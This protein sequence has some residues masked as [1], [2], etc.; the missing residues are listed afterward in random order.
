MKNLF[1]HMLRRPRLVFLSVLVLMVVSAVVVKYRIRMVTNLD[2]YMP[3]E[4]PAF[5]FSDEA[6]NRFNIRDAILIVLEHPVTV[7]NPGTLEKMIRLEDE[8][9]NFPEIDSEF[10]TSLHT[11]DNIVATEEG[12]DVRSFFT[13]PPQRD[14]ECK[15]IRNLVRENNMIYGR[16]VSKDEIAALIIVDL[17]KNTFTQDLYE[18][19]MSLTR[20]YQ[21]PEKIYLAGRPIVEGTMAL[22]GPRDMA[23]M[24][25]LVVIVIAL[26][27]LLVLRSWVR[28]L[29]SL[30]VVLA[31][32]LGSFA[33]MTG[34]GI[35]FYTVTIMVPVML[36]A[37]GVA[38]GIHLYNQADYYSRIHPEA[39]NHELAENMID[40]ILSPV[41]F[42]ALTTMAGFISLLTS[43]VYP[44][45]Y[46]GIFSAIGVAGEFVLSLLLIPAGMILFGSRSKNTLSSL[47]LSDLPSPQK[48]MESS[49]G[50][51]FADAILA[52]PVRVFLVT[53]ILLAVSVYGI[54]RVWINT[55]FLDNFERDSE[56]VRTD[57]LVNAR[58]GG[59]STFNV[60]LDS[61]KEDLFKDPTVLNLMWEA[62]KG[63]LSLDRVGD[64]MSI[65]DY[66]RR[67]NLVMHED[68][69]EFET[70]P[71]SSD[72]IAQY[73]LLYELSGNP[74]NLWKLVDSSYKSANMK[75]QL[76]SDDSQTM[77]R[78]MEYFDSF[79]EKFL[80]LGVQVGYAGSGYK[81]MVF[82]DLILKGQISSLAL[83]VL[84]VIGLVAFM[85]KDILLGMIAAIPVGIAIVI[86][87]GIMGLF[88]VPLTSST[89]LISSIAVGIGVDY[90]IH[91]IERYRETMRD[92]GNPLYAGR[93]A[94]SLTGRAVF[95]NAAI[96]IS[97]FLVLLF[98]VFPPNRQVGAL[99]SLNMVTAFFATI[100][101]LFLVLRKLYRISEEKEK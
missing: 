31:S 41:L 22:L 9:T 47:P 12:L 79:R 76:K 82:A 45:K 61:G 26:V 46:F 78:I 49:L 15:E 42:A 99:V 35:P 52:H 88:D 13:D 29:I 58:F 17:P 50:G 5:V 57:G 34:L 38:Y 74:E 54:G 100:T 91:F 67:M 43:Q 25:P 92:T 73:L 95:L 87:F 96:V 28:M 59:T 39:N 75:I 36:I 69:V 60:I 89:A 48:T 98:S 56:I 33:L 66:L 101:V 65:V 40:T 80:Q 71:E 24:G 20:S 62:Q 19:L 64:A 3:K 11:A 30:G 18:R 85:F 83:S 8:L 53:G 27:L 84:I 32:T 10:I 37:I 97:G 14:E 90:A 44:V 77:K 81:S 16:L 70:V 93:F 72:L 23:R 55:S 63:A 6:D 51:R 1:K 94:M 4:H 21:G 2:E 68:K 7:F 86:N